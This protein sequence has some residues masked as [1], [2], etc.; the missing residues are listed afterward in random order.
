MA[1]AAAAGATD[2]CLLLICGGFHRACSRITFS[3][4][5]GGVEMSRGKQGEGGGRRARLIGSG[6]IDAWKARGSTAGGSSK[7]EAFVIALDQPLCRSAKKIEIFLAW[8]GNAA[9][10]PRPICRAPICNR[11][12]SKA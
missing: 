10:L 4:G 6:R 7:A 1:R 9:Q 2:L 3:R 11:K 5:S 12:V 8:V